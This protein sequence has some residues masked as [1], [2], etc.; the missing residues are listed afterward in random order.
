[1]NIQ[2]QI[3]E[4]TKFIDRAAVE[5]A[6][7]FYMYTALEKILKLYDD[8]DGIKDQRVMELMNILDENLTG[9]VKGEIKSLNNID[10]ISS[11]LLAYAS[12]FDEAYTVDELF[13]VMDTSSLTLFMNYIG[14]F[15]ISSFAKKTTE[16]W[17]QVKHDIEAM[18]GYIEE[19][20]DV[21][22]TLKN[23]ILELFHDPEE[24]KMRFIYIVKSFYRAYKP[25]EEEILKKAHSE[26]LRYIKIFNENPKKFMDAYSYN[27]LPNK[28]EKWEY[29]VNIYISYILQM[30]V[31]FL[32]MKDFKT[33]YGL[34]IIGCAMKEYIEGITLRSSIDR[35]LKLMA[36]PNRYKILE[37]LS[38]K[39]W[40][41]QALSKELNLT[42]TTIHH[43]IQGFLALELLLI[44]KEDNKI[45]YTLDKSKVKM[46]LDFLYNSILN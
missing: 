3:K 35:F 32:S 34:M 29:K 44:E 24:T 43:H 37:L 21:E 9:F 12:D 1:M 5:F 26:K 15:F 6:E 11:I 19:L 38:K 36:D 30:G 2:E 27:F 28:G 41:I 16:D 23:T 8:L 4:N 18:K 14:G 10:V 40:Y 46:Y 22:D 33:E 31:G 20:Q 39:P 17:D 45:L 25:F 42:P 7:S 13:K